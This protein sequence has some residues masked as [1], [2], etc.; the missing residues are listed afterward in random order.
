MAYIAIHI[1]CAS[2]CTVG[3]YLHNVV[4]FYLFLN[5]NRVPSESLSR[6]LVSTILF[7]VFCQDCEIKIDVLE[8]GRN[9]APFAN[10]AYLKRI[11]FEPVLILIFE[12]ASPKAQIWYH[13]LFLR[14]VLT[15]E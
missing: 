9:Y 4:P 5:L 11:T 2:A 14:A 7:C 15:E 13:S 3:S 8:F 1:V 12:T 6:S 10:A